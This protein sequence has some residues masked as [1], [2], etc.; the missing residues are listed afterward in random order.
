MQDEGVVRAIGVSN[1]YDVGVL[2][3][4]DRERKVQIVQ[5]RWYEGN[6]WDR[7]VW[8]YCKENGI[9]Y[10]CVNISE[11]TFYLLMVDRIGRFGH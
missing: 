2:K 3:E 11:C 8:A 9:V 4:L 7:E 1:V 6:D 5:N 10:Q